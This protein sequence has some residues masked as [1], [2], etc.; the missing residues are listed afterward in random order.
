V[1]S[2]YQ[3][4]G[5]SGEERQKVKFSFMKR[6]F[7]HLKRLRAEGREVVLCGDWNIAHKEIDL[8]N[9]RGN[10]KNSGFLPEERE[11]LTRTVAGE[12]HAVAQTGHSTLRAALTQPRVWA[13]AVAYFG[14]VLALYGFNFWLPSLISAHGVSLQYTGW[15]AA[16]P[17]LCGAPFMV[18][19]GRHSDRTGERV[20]HLVAVSVLGFLGFAAAGAV[21]SLAGQILCLCVAVM[22]VYGSFPVFWTLPT[23]FL[24]GTGAAAGLAM[25]NSLGNL[26]GYLGP[27]VVAWLTR[28][29]GGDFGRA[30]LALGISML[31][32]AIVVLALRS[33][34][35]ATQALDRELSAPVR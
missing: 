5:S 11:W 29:T 33:G 22:G 16:L 27:Q 30:L 4:S 14:I 34:K 15:I 23:A 28:D 35:L 31:T 24:A 18:W 12:R 21:D 10:R 1:I 19:W 32:P 2:V 6:F 9:W 17:F 25:I 26:A 3:P 13:L 7:P 20:L 8:K